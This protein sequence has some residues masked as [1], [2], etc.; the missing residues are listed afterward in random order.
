MRD[1][2]DKNNGVK[3]EK[4]KRRAGRKHRKYNTKNTGIEENS[5]QNQLKYKS[6]LCKNFIETGR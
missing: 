4:P 6:E 1:I 2:Q 5:D 3:R